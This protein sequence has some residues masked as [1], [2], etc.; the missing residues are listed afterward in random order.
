MKLDVVPRP[1]SRNAR[2]DG[3]RSCPAHGTRV[4]TPARRDTASQP[5]PC[6]TSTR[7]GPHAAAL[8]KYP[9]PPRTAPPCIA[10][11]WLANSVRLMGFSMRKSSRGL[12]PSPKF[13]KSDQR[14]HRGVCVLPAIFA[15]A[16]DVALDVS[17]IVRRVIER[18]RQQQHQ[19][20]RPPHQ[21]LIDSGHGAHSARRAP[22][23]R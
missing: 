16:R 22:P 10:A 15:N 19:P 13:R 4:S 2:I 5:N 8:H 12:S 18:R 9:P 17:R 1:V 11:H 23:R 20:I 14:P 7:R 21:L 3:Q 6:T